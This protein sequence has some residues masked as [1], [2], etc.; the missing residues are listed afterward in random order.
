[1]TAACKMPTCETITFGRSPLC[2]IH[3][4]EAAGA[5]ERTNFIIDILAKE[6]NARQWSPQTAFE[7]IFGAVSG[8]LAGVS[9]TRDT[10]EDNIDNCCT[11]IRRHARLHW[12]AIQE[13]EAAKNNGGVPPR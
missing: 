5:A 6:V 8:Q 3:E 10:L 13:E 9:N 1:M 11:Q 2:S 4:K 12:H 7:A